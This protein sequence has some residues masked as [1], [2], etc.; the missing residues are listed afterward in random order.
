MLLVDLSNQRKIVSL[1]AKALI[2]G[3]SVVRRLLASLVL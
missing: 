3:E 2:L 1:R